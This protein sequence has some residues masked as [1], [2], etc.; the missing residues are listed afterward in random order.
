MNS[1]C[2]RMLPTQTTQIISSL[3]VVYVVIKIKYEISN[4]N[5]GL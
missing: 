3:L 4:I 5:S 1:E 2:V